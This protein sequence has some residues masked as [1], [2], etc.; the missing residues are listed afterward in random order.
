MFTSGNVILDTEPWQSDVTAKCHSQECA[1]P[2]SFSCQ[3]QLTCLHGMLASLS[4]IFQW[5]IFLIRILTSD[6]IACYLFRIRCHIIY[7]CLFFSEMKA[8]ETWEGFVDCISAR[9]KYINTFRY[10]RT[11]RYIRTSGNARGARVDMGKPLVPPFNATYGT[12]RVK[13]HL[14]R[15]RVAR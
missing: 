7:L 11:E 13:R 8:K 15:P 6:W 10:F 12:R 14:Q 5:F 2:F 4:R 1:R 9:G 3:N